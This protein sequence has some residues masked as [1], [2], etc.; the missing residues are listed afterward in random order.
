MRRLLDV[1]TT[2]AQPPASY[3][4]RAVLAIAK[5]LLALVTIR[6]SLPFAFEHVFAD[7]AVHPHTSIYLLF[8]CHLSIVAHDDLLFG[9]I[10]P[11]SIVS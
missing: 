6:K 9:S 3:S 1:V 8:Y 7:S 5:G 10:F 2:H 4:E 11:C